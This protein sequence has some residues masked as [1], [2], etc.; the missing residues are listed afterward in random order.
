[1]RMYYEKNRITLT[2]QKNKSRE[3]VVHSSSTHES[4]SQQ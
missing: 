2:I 1:M 4:D 3:T